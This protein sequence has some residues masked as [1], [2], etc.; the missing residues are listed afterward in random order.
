[1]G[2]LRFARNDEGCDNDGILGVE[3]DCFASLAMTELSNDG[4]SRNDGIPAMTQ[5]FLIRIAVEAKA[6]LSF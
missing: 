2:L 1:M 4:G 6:Q 5:G 3:W